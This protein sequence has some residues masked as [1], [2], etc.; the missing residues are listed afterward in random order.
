MK[1]ILTILAV[2]VSLVSCNKFADLNVSPT[3]LA[4]PT[5]RGLLTNS[6][7]SMP[8]LMLGNTAAARNGS[9]YVQ[10]LAEG[11]YPGPS[12]Y[13]DKNT[14]FTTWY[15]GPLYNLQKII[16]YNTNASPFAE[17]GANGSSAN[18]IA[19]AR[20]L[21]AYYYLQM[22]DRWG[23]IPYSQALKGS[24]AFAPVYDK[25]QDIYTALFKE[26]KEANDQIK[27]AEAGVSGDVLLGGDMASWKRFANTTR[28]IMALRLSKADAAKGKTEYAAAVADGVI[29]SVTQN[30]NYKFLGGDPN[31]YNPWYNNYSVSFRNDYAVSTTVTNYMEARTDP[32]LKVYGENLTGGV[33]KGLTY[34]KVTAVNIPAVYSRIGDAFRGAGSSLNI[35]SY[36]QVLFMMAEAN[37]IGYTTGGDAGAMANYDL[38]IAAS[39]TENG[40]SGAAGYVAQPSVAYSA[41][42]GYQQI[43]T[44]KWVSMYLKGWEAWNDW[45][46]TGFPVLTAAADGVD[47]RGIP[48][49]QG[50]PTNESS[51]NGT[52]YT[53]AIAQ[54][55]GDNNYVKVWWNK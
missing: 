28:M 32:R 50:Y 23:D 1:R 13:S 51:L 34:G 9:L 3:S 21:K 55:G 14:S 5:T 27:T 4:A 36:S 46:R 33:V 39:F 48:L 45:R 26:L 20:I 16:E 10:Y 40:V 11:P 49:R 15:T 47:A 22:T 6:L 7:Q 37:K 43:M 18:Q 42:T 52:N 54:M 17:T 12:L 25:Q 2:C 29:T 41:A 24:D 8:D 38:A 35:Y 30:I 31:N 19:V 53:A 44:E